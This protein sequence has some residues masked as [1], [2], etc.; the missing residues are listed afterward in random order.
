MATLINQTNTTG[1]VEDDQITG[2]TGNDTLAGGA[3][4]DSLV[5]GLGNDTLTGGAGNDFFAFTTPA[6]SATNFDTITDFSSGDTLVFST[7]VYSGLGPVGALNANQF[8][9][10]IG[11]VAATTAEDRFFYNTSSGILSYDADGSASGSSA[12]QVVLIG[13][14]NHPALTATDFLVVS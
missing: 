8:A 1:T 6:N 9:S 13:V 5:G 2:T 10:G 11:L 7:S 12:V 3:G 4:N 14:S